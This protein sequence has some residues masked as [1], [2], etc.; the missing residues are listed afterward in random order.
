MKYVPEWKKQRRMT[1]RGAKLTT[2]AWNPF[3]AR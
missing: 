2:G 1:D 3:Y